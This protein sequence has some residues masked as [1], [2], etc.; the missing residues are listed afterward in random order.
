MPDKEW[1]IPR[2]NFALIIR[3]NTKGGRVESFASI[4]IA[5]LD[6]KWTDI[7]RYDTAHGYAHR[8]VL[9]RIEGLRGK[10]PT[11]MLNYSQAFQYA[12]RDLEQNAEIYLAD[13]LAH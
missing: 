6:G 4:L 5:F 1:T 13:F 8:D 11:P 10:L 9:G 2:G 7:T 3:R 12:I